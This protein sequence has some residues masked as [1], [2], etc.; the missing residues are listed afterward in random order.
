MTLE[1]SSYATSAAFNV[2]MNSNSIQEL[3]RTYKHEYEAVR[4]GKNP[5]G[6][7]IILQ[8][9]ATTSYLLRRGLIRLRAK[10]VDNVP[11]W[12]PIHHY[13]TKP[14]IELSRLLISA[15]FAYRGAECEQSQEYWDR[16]YSSVNIKP[17]VETLIVNIARWG[18]PPEDWHALGLGS[19]VDAVSLLLG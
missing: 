11:Q 7:G 3:L 12:S 17:P 1:F 5:G 18:V 9:R 15:G 4:R 19:N 10:R 6:F 13:L 8:N 16:L 2:T 14:G